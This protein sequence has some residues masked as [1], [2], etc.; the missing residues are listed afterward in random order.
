MTK[1]KLQVATV[2]VTLGELTLSL[3]DLH[4]T[5]CQYEQEQSVQASLRTA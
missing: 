1:R 5:H 2:T 3:K 4:L